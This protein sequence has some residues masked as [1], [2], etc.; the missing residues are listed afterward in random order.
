[1]AKQIKTSRPWNGLAGYS[2]A[3]D[4]PKNPPRGGS[5][6]PPSPPRSSPKK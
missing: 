4:G 2:P 3:Y 1:M 6:L 5:A